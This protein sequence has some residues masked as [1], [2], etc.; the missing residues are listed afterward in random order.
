[1]TW[2]QIALAILG[3]ASIYFLSSKD[4]KYIKYGFIFGLLAEPLWFYTA[5][6]HNQ[7]GVMFL[8]I[9]YGVCHVRGLYN[10]YERDRIEKLSSKG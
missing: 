3:F 9:C 5:Y 7:M 4:I 8:C 2:D 10:F 1:M 6:V